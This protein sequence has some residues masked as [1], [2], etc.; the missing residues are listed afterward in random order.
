MHNKTA[1][2]RPNSQTIKIGP[3]K[4][5]VSVQQWK[6]EL[7]VISLLLHCI[8]NGS[9]NIIHIY[10]KRRRKNALVVGAILI[11]FANAIAIR[12]G[13]ATEICCSFRGSYDMHSVQIF[14]N[15]KSEHIIL[16]SMCCL[17]R[18]TF[19]L[20]AI[21]ANYCTSSTFYYWLLL[22]TTLS[23]NLMLFEREKANNNKWSLKA[24]KQ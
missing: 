21:A 1:I 6:P 14:V 7:N 10:P 18:F 4:R 23:K 11:W 20:S 19:Y 24:H 3:V 5:T 16:G 2:N 22:S 8:I 13:K 12:S 15:L 17:A 9:N